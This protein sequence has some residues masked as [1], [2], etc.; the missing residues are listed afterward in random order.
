MNVHKLLF[1]ILLAVNP[2][3]WH[4]HSQQKTLES[5]LDQITAHIQHKSTWHIQ[6]SHA[7][8]VNKVKE[9]LSS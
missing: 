9:S 8:H 7:A 5:E 6:A 4:L 1:M 2:L 3:T